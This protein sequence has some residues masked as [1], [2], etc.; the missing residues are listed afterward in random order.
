MPMLLTPCLRRPPRFSWII[1]L[2]FFLFFTPAGIYAQETGHAG[3]YIEIGGQTEPAAIGVGLGAYNYNYRYLTTRMAMY[4]LGSESVDNVFL[5]ADAGIRM[6]LGT[7][8]SPFVGLG[9]Y[10]GYHTD[11]VP[12]ENDNLDNDGDG[13]VDE[14]GEKDA[15]IDRSMASIYPEAGLHVWIDHTNRL[16][17]SGKYHLT[18]EGR[19]SD[20]WL[21]CFGIYF[22][23]P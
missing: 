17:L 18:T 15:R 20:F 19:D 23:V 4:V 3:P 21:F 9:G 2:N 6:E 22:A 16:T 13:Q 8:V 12:A 1:L 7:Q 5:G 10:Y 14:D 11:Q